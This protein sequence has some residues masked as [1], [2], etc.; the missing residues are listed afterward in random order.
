MINWKLRLKNKVTLTTL[1]VSILALVYMILAILGI[2]P[3]VT[4]D[5]IKE[6]VMLLI[7]IFVILGIVIDPTTEGV[8]DSAL[9][10]SYDEPSPKTKVY[11][12]K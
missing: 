8:G 10:N 1:T 7:N 6:V 3:K 2:T 9:A 12:G 4:Q 11:G 5:E